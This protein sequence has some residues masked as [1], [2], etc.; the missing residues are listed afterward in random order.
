MKKTTHYKGHRWTNDELRLIMKM[1][2][3]DVPLTEIA[4]ATNSTT[5][6]ILCQVQRMRKNGIPLKRRDKGHVQGRT[7]T[8]W[9]QGEV[10]YL[11]RRRRERATSESIAIELNRSANAVDG[12]IGRLRREGLTV[13]MR[14]KGVRRLWDAESLRVL[15]LDDIAEEQETP[16]VTSSQGGDPMPTIMPSQIYA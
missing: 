6:A 10:E 7:N 5:V 16:T 1:W 12:M 3:E 13:N 15:A 14:G 9:T 8:P 4:E 2:A 11:L